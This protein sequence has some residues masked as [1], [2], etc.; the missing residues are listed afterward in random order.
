MGKKLP[1]TI[2]L[3]V[4]EGLLSGKSHREIA[5][6]LELSPG[7]VSNILNQYIR[8]QVVDIDLLRSIAVKMKDQDLEVDDLAYSL[9]LRNMLKDLELSEERMD[10]FLEALSV[11]NYKNDIQNPENFIHKVEEVSDYVD[12]LDLSVFDLID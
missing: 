3:K 11:Y 9:H 7:S 5:S 6:C 12:R 10:D 4:L 1:R 8:K 2:K